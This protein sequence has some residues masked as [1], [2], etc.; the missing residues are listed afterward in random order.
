[1]KASFCGFSYSAVGGA[2]PHSENCPQYVLTR[3]LIGTLTV[4]SRGTRFAQRYDYS[5]LSPVRRQSIGRDALKTFLINSNMACSPALLVKRAMGDN[6][7]FFKELLA[8]LSEFFFQ[9]K[10]N[11]H[12]AAFVHIYRALERIS[13]SFPLI[14]CSIAK[15]FSHTYKTL[16]KF[17]QDE[18]SGELS[19]LKAFISKTDFIDNARKDVVLDIDFS[20]LGDSLGGKCLECLEGLSTNLTQGMGG[21]LTAGIKFR[22]VHDL[23]VTTRNRFLHARTG[24]GAKNIKMSQIND[25]D[26][27]FSSLNG[28]FCSY[29]AQLTLETVARKYGTR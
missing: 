12:T 18:N 20:H 29:V 6:R 23:F 10:R 8:E 19:F 28:V 27:F 11:C 1:M 14:Y 3:L 7:E 5:R 17:V 4:S 26:A 9:S 24:D 13:F 16:Q 25:C 15:D 2:T 22:D 21:P